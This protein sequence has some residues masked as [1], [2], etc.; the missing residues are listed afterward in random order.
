V[1]AR[2]VAALLL[3]VALWFIVSAEEPSAAWVPVRVRVTLDRSVRLREPLPTVRAFVSG[4]RRDVLRL[5]QSPP[6]LQRAITEDTPDS[7]RLELREQDL[8]FPPGVDVRVRDLRPR[9]MTVR[10]QATA[11]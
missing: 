2:A 10:L 1:I 8:D 3:A 7:V 5:V 4:R 11:R 6:V 9:L